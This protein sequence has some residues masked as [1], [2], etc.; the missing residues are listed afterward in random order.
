[1]WV[2]TITLKIKSYLINL[3]RLVTKLNIVDQVNWKII[4]KFK[5]DLI[6]KQLN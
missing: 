5:S 4:N 1:M 6:T 2:V 3:I